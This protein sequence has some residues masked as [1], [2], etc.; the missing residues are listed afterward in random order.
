VQTI[1][2]TAKRQATFPAQLC[3]DMGIQ[4]GDQIELIPTTRNGKR[5]WTLKPVRKETPSYFGML[6]KYVKK[7]TRPW[8]RE[9]D[10]DATGA[11]WARD[12]PV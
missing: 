3:A 12:E 10:G 6:R 7:G 2:L 5:V 8:T 9:T 11:A 4:P 1:K